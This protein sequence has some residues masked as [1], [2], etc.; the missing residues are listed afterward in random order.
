MQTA[1]TLTLD[2]VL[3]ISC[4][5]LLR[6]YFELLQIAGNRRPC[7]RHI[8]GSAIQTS[9][10]IAIRRGVFLQIHRTLIQ[11]LKCIFIRQSNETDFPPRFFHLAVFSLSPS[12]FV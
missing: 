10:G 4:V 6:G 12:I 3:F 2:S 1:Q 9:T 7:F 5:Y 11:S 8:K